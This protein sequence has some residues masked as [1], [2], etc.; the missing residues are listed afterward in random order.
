[1]NIIQNSTSHNT[2]GNFSEHVSNVVQSPITAYIYQDKQEKVSD[3]LEVGSDMEFRLAQT[4]IKKPD[5]SVVQRFTHHI[6]NIEVEFYFQLN[7]NRYYALFWKDGYLYCPKGEIFSAKTWVT[8]R[9]NI[10]I[11]MRN[12]D[13]VYFIG[14]FN[15]HRVKNVLD[16]AET[17]ILE[18]K[19][20]NADIKFH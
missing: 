4:S 19:R 15:R 20:K 17:K 10:E 3:D 1:M 18:L 11:E 9:D 5:L 6:K 14:I 8:L 2:D 16:K 13:F 7:E 12:A